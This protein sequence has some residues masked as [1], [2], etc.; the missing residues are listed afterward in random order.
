VPAFGPNV[1]LYFPSVSF[2]FEETAPGSNLFRLSDFD[3]SNGTAQA[4]ITFA[5]YTDSDTIVAVIDQIQ[6][7]NEPLDP[8]P[9]PATLPLLSS[10]LGIL[11]IAGCWR[12]RKR[13]RRMPA[14]A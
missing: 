5:T 8:T 2:S 14:A 3:F 4:G 11:G 13:I 1:E 10:G 6:L 9:L 12:R 7:S